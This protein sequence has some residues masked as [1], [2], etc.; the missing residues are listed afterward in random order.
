MAQRPR[1]YRLR[2]SFMSR[3]ASQT[4]T[5][6]KPWLA[7]GFL[8]DT[9]IPGHAHE[10]WKRAFLLSAACLPQRSCSPW[11][12]RSRRYAAELSDYWDVPVFAHPLEIPYSLAGLRIRRSIPHARLSWRF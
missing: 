8:I 5:G 4:C 10:W 6:E 2:T 1:E 12:F 7:D 11:P 3:P 9:G